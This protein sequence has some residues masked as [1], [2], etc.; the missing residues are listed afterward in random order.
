LDYVRNRLRGGQSIHPAISTCVLVPL[1]N[2]SQKSIASEYIEG[3]AKSQPIT[4][5]SV[6]FI[7]E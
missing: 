2:N 6:S 3:S 1:R 7:G 5:A 4:E